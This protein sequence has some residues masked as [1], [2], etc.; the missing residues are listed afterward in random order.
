MLWELTAVLAVSAALPQML[1]EPSKCSLYGTCGKRTVF[2]A[3][4]PCPNVTDPQPLTDP[5]AINTLRGLCGPELA[6]SAVCCTAAQVEQLAENLKKVEPMIGSCPACQRNFRDL[7]CHFTCSPDQ[8]EFVEVTETSNSLDGREVVKELNFG[9]DNAFSSSFYDSCKDV[10]FGATNG[11]AMDLIGGG[12]KNFTQFLKFLG[13]EKPLLGGSP[14]QMNFVPNGL[15]ITAQSCADGDFRCA[16]VD[17]ALACPQPDPRPPPSSH[18][19]LVSVLL[20]L[21]YVFCLAASVIAW[22][23]AKNTSKRAAQFLERRRLIHDEDADDDPFAT[24][25]SPSLRPYPVNQKIQAGIKH[26]ASVSSRF[27]WTC[28]VLCSLIAL[29]CSLG[30]F[31]AQLETD[32]EALW[33]STNAKEAEERRF[34]DDKF[35]PFYRTEQLVVTNQTGGPVLSSET[36]AWLRDVETRVSQL[37]TAILA[38]SLDSFC[39]KPINDACVV[40]SV[41]QWFYRRNIDNSWDSRI[42]DCAASPVKCLP[43]FQQPVEPNIVLGGAENGALDSK[44]LVTTWVIRNDAENGYQSRVDIWEVELQSLF[45]VFS[46]EA[47]LMGLNL[48]FSTASSLK[49]E[50]TRSA[51][52]DIGIIAL[53]YALMFVYVS[54]SLGGRSRRRFGLGLLGVL[55]VL[56]SVFAAIGACSLAGVK[57]TLVITE[58]IPFLALAIGV[59][60]VFLLVHQ[61]DLFTEFAT[62]LPVE[63]RV[64]KAVESIGPSICLATA[65]EVSALALGAVVA[66]P[67]VRNFAVFAAVAV[68][69]NS[70][71]QLTLFVASM[72]IAVKRQEPSLQQVPESEADASIVSNSA[73][74]YA[75]EVQHDPRQ[76]SQ[77]FTTRYTPFLLS[78]N[79]KRCVAAI[80]MIWFA[81]SLTLL[82][83]LELGLDQRL[84]VPQD[85]F[86]VDYFT[87]IQKWLSVGPPV[88]F[89]VD[90]PGAED[91]DAQ[92]KMCGRFAPCHVDSIP[93]VLEQE[94]KRPDVSFLAAPAASWIDDFF[95]WTNPTLSSCCREDSSGLPCIRGRDC[96]TC[97]EGSVWNAASMEGLPAYT[98]FTHYLSHWLEA[99]SD[100]CPLAGK[101]PYG[102]A[103]ARSADGVVLAAHWRTSHTPLRSQNDY[104]NAY[105]AARAI[106]TEISRSTGLHVFPYSVFYEFFAQYTTIV[107]LSI[108]LVAAAHFIVFALSA[109]LLGSVKTSAIVTLAVMM[110]TVNIAGSMVMFNVSLNALSLV[111][112]VICV[113]LGV[114]FC[115][116]I[117]RSFTFVPK[118]SLVG[119]RGVTRADRAYNALS[120]TGGSIFSGIAVTKLIGVA[121]LGLARSK[122]FE[123][124]YFRMWL[125]LVFTATVHALALLPVLLSSFGGAAWLVEDEDF[126]GLMGLEE[127]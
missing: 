39:L 22:R 74:A 36:L 83:R 71:L 68:L 67:A 108:G 105:A 63:D 49:R 109:L 90:S 28:V 26:L 51:H 73:N 46:R 91:R 75:V 47:D 60:N 97:Y 48:S 55:V 110:S 122:I 8:H 107:P 88:Y 93:N 52:A 42:S 79:I 65:C 116:H 120:G 33:V 70:I 121:V 115:I 103:V 119:I 59:D 29:I 100:S 6:S 57:M 21:G 56:L 14:F 23:R 127:L 2:G 64:I 35:G 62:N 45:T 43:P 40:E 12:A 7:F 44:A 19:G 81:V 77:I 50:L 114:E 17:C 112:L 13:D 84:A 11:K 87:D 92:L 89:V 32:P 111:N 58:V 30:L 102:N 117:A 98:N 125:A 34:F 37:Q 72:T 126:G 31:Y 94:R 86:L 18:S 5:N 25:E 53:S 99:P 118:I 113:G 1:N 85:S 96:R 76:F 82:P 78:R 61:L 10:Q 123:V 4:L 41:T 9:V 95:Q 20:L 80:F 104:I 106:S 124:Y 27:P 15:N 24:P 16:C 3:D 54:I 69:F 38:D 66:M 101:A